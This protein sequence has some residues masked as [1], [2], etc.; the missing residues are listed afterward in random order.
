MTETAIFF[1]V[2]FFHLLLDWRPVRVEQASAAFSSVA[3]QGKRSTSPLDRTS[4]RDATQ[5]PKWSLEKGNGG[6][7]AS[8]SGECFFF[9][10]PLLWSWTRH[11]HLR[12][13]HRPWTEQRHSFWGKSG[14]PL[15]RSPP[16]SSWLSWCGCGCLLWNAAS[17]RSQAQIYSRWCWEADLG[18]FLKNL[19][20]T[21]TQKSNTNNS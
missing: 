11:T 3:L 2:F 20:G 6:E 14:C 4:C 17:C 8:L 7:G 12:S 1:L 10:H 21:R 5:S 15:W 16:L 19:I 13:L 18:W 9:P